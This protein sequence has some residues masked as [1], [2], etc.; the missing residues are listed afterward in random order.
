MQ[1][2]KVMLETLS[3]VVVSTRGG[4]AILTETQDFFSGSVLRGVLAGRYI[5]ARGLGRAAHEDEDFRRLFCGGLRFLPAY[6]AIDGARSYVLPLSLQKDKAG[7]H[8]LDLIYASDQEKEDAKGY[9][10][11]RGFGRITSDGQL[12]TA[13]VATEISLHMSRSGDAERIA[14]RSADG[15]IY[16]YEAIAAGEKF[17]G[18]IIGS[19]V[20]LEELRAVLCPDGNPIRSLI[21]RSRHTQYG[22]CRLTLSAAEACDPQQS[23]SA[24]ERLYLRL[25]TP[26]LPL[27]G[28][29]ANAADALREIVG[30]FDVDAAL[31]MDVPV[32]S[33]AQEVENFVGVW[34]MRRPRAMGLAAGT[35][36]AV[37]KAAGVWSDE[38]IRRVQELCLRGFG[39]RTEE[40]FGQVRIWP[41]HEHLHIPSHDATPEVRAASPVTHELH[42]R[43][44]D[45]VRAILKRRCIA[46]LRLYAMRD[47]EN[48]H[49]A[50]ATNHFFARLASIIQTNQSNRTWADAMRLIKS[51]V[52]ATGSTFKNV[53][54]KIRIGDGISLEKSLREDM[55]APYDEHMRRWHHA[56]FGEDAAP[57]AEELM[58]MV[59][60]DMQSYT[61]ELCRAYWQTFLR[62]A[63]KS[64]GV[65][66]VEEG[67]Q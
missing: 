44:R 57:Q 17:V 27:C 21:G 48:I 62:H 13:S 56:A 33:A 23:A 32:S 35:V 20:D 65:E 34:G 55:T 53:L 36:F 1:L 46:Q 6:P 42:A 51:D 38:E 22:R 28:G 43:V 19:E 54:K 5:D 61:D 24:G 26:F 11:C 41:A 45:G 60:F 7:T 58:R 10:G 4:A 40:G 9:K 30:A 3:P 63:R 31:D 16:N 12:R 14:G 66:T 37:K 18:A 47:A 8:V 2:I 67:A 15:N 29:C 52:D 64:G 25:D 39:R 50:G 49:G 59:D